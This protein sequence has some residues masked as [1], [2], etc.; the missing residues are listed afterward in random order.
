MWVRDAGSHQDGS[1][2]DFFDETS[3]FRRM[4]QIFGKTWW[5][6]R[7][8]DSLTKI[9]F[10]NRI[11]RGSRYARNGS[12]QN[13][14]VVDNQIIARV[15]GSR[16]LPY[17][18]EITVPVINKVQQK[19][20]L[21]RIRI[22]KLII[23]S[24][25]NREV[26]PLLDQEALAMGITLFPDSWRS[27]QMSCSCPDFAVP[28]KHIAA[29][30]YVISE[31]IDR[32]PFFLL[33]MKGL[34]LERELKELRRE[35]SEAP[36]IPDQLS[37]FTKE[38]KKITASLTSDSVQEPDLSGIPNMQDHLF[39]L[40]EPSPVFWKNDFRL[41]LDERLE[42][43]AKNCSKFSDG[44]YPGEFKNTVPGIRKGSALTI[45]LNHD[46]VP[47]GFMV[48][49]PG[50]STHQVINVSSAIQALLSIDE[51]EK[52]DLHPTV[53]VLHT[54]LN[55]A[56]MLA[57]KSAL[58]PLLIRTQK[59]TY[60]IV[61]MPPA[62]I[63]ELEQLREYVSS[64]CSQPLLV[65]NFMEG[66]KTTACYPKAGLEL[67]W[68][69]SAFLG[70]LVGEFSYNHPDYHKSRRAVFDA[71]LPVRDEIPDLF[72]NN[73]PVAF[74]GLD[75]D[76]FPS[77]IA[78]WLSKYDIGAK[79]WKPVLVIKERK[80]IFWLYI[81][82][83]NNDLAIPQQMT[84]ADFQQS[85]ESSL[86][87]ADFIADL[88]KLKEIIPEIGG[89]VKEG[90]FK[91]VKIELNSLVE[92][93]YRKRQLLAILGIELLIPKSLKK[94]FVPKLSMELFENKEERQSFFS[95]DEMLSF[96]WTV[97]IGDEQISPEEF[98]KIAETSGHI[99]KIRNR[100]VL[101]DRQEIAVIRNK[102]NSNYQPSSHQVL[103]SALSGA[104]EGAKVFFN[105][106][107]NTLI[108]QLTEAPDI[109]V[110]KGIHAKLR[111]YQHRGFS[112]MY[113]NLRLGMG[114][115]IAD[116]MGLGKTLQVI[117]V[118]EKLR[119]ESCFKK[120]P[121]LI[122]VPTSLLSNWQKE[123][124]QF[125]P[126]M[127]VSVYHGSSRSLST[128]KVDLL[129][130]TYGT[131]RS[132]LDKFKGSQWPVLI[133]D[134]AQNM[135]NAN[136][137][138][139]KAIRSIEAKHRIAMSGTPVENRLG[140]YWSIFDFVLP[141]YLGNQ[142][143]FSQQYAV[144]ISR[145]RDEIKL[146]QFRSI[147]KP[148]ILR[149]VK[150]DPSIIKDL[151][152]KMVNDVWCNLEKKQAAVYKNIVDDTMMQIGDLE[153][154]IERRGAILKLLTSLKQ[155]CNHP[156]QFLKRGQA[157]PSASGKTEVLLSILETILSQGEKCLIF[158]Q[159]K[160][161]GDLLVQMLSKELDMS[162][163]FLHGALSRSK[164]DELIRNF[165]EDPL[166]KIFILSLKAGGTGLNLTMA[167]HVIHY[168][169]WWNPATE[170]QATDR[171][172]RIGQKKN[173]MV[174][175]L[176]CKGTLEENIN[177]MLKN[178]RELASLTVSDGENWIGNMNDRELKQ[179]V[180]LV[181]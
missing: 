118:L 115:L 60:R 77:S 105:S 61:W 137:A 6:K 150:T 89:F 173:V 69:L 51:Y 151:P 175:R 36:I 37:F 96:K 8:L 176:L 16:R 49:P 88:M 76:A 100:Y 113:K 29:L 17:K 111:P 84:I 56:L 93:L 124:E 181:Q 107:V 25:I 45:L 160:E 146:E 145:F 134:E 116:D 41:E 120:L 127:R 67:E 155:T 163:P 28:C 119:E 156:V 159:Y 2:F 106:R 63:P 44:F 162:I 33:K 101:L 53:R 80:A 71:V 102:I 40:L 34:D 66:K 132:D 94:L 147:T 87:K 114:C 91:G 43:L 79:K 90:G 62:S 85:R 21:E 123:L 154:G 122:I 167:N 35:N 78:R 31:M 22:N 152:A 11:Q 64:L 65:L 131:L 57:I 50:S 103:H 97:S 117:S 133:V 3:L 153:E 129:L 15:Q 174:Y 23:A 54:C 7:W 83:V 68:L 24:F 141:G 109:K 75:A 138:Q 82:V 99:V 128:N 125:C 166:Q 47:E 72:F 13:V 42:L 149:R 98:F 164:R 112:W 140:D 39:Q 59:N 170:D 52:R 121:A 46:L 135:K 108:R 136:T 177:E 4:K 95:L 5:G 157:V 48:S 178:K 27:L 74:K 26:S 180:E 12:V 30:I 1:A 20:L 148:F 14:Q 165:S 18:V 73:F 104:Y 126:H 130:T 81:E 179:F 142:A 10:E 143:S 38:Q 158:T 161:M 144:P 32:D 172:Y 70:I 92:I 168:D 171:T 58:R 139:S 86:T 169:L 55:A 110:P 9:D 19:Q